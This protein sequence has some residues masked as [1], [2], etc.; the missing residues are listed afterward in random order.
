MVKSL[1]TP[2]SLCS[3]GIFKS[4]DF[5]FWG[6][7]PLWVGFLPWWKFLILSGIVLGPFNVHQIRT[8]WSL[9]T[10][11]IISTRSSPSPQMFSSRTRRST[12]SSLSCHSS[13]QLSHTGTILQYFYSENETHNPYKDRRCLKYDIVD[14]MYV[15]GLCRSR[16]VGLSYGLS[17]LE[18]EDGGNSGVRGG[19]G[20]RSPLQ[21]E[22]PHTKIL[23]LVG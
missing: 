10:L 20:L 21:E 18:P 22:G 14:G 19:W 5:G 3:E 11:F 2:T 4:N 16:P 8:F 13:T 12:S 17:G 15:H 23:F 9:C 7:I 6:K 1:D